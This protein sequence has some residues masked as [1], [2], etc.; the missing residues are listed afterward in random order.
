MLPVRPWASETGDAADLD[1][2]LVQKSDYSVAILRTT[3]C[4]DV[5]TTTLGARIAQ[6]FFS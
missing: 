3:E 2:L 1:I 5:P 6:L 4:R